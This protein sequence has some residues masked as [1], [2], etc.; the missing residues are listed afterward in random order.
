MIFF[1]LISILKVI[2]SF[3]YM[4]M[5]SNTR[6]KWYDYKS[7]Q[8][9]MAVFESCFLLEMILQ[10]F[11]KVTPDGQSTELKDIMAI[12]KLYIRSN[13]IWHLIPLIPF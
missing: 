1:V 13:F 10:F 7:V 4:G 2:S 8:V 9:Q 3:F 12:T 11:R 6:V 5:F